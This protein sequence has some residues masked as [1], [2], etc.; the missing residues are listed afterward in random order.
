M[1]LFRR[2]ALLALLVLPSLPAAAALQAWLDR[3][4]VAP[5]E[6][7]ELTL[8]RDGRGDS[9]PDLAP[10]QR[11]FDILG[12]ASGTSV[13]IV[14]GHMTAQ[15]Q[16]RLTLSPKHDG[17]IALPPLN[18]GGERTPALVLSVAANAAGAADKA[19]PGA[20][21]SSHVFLTSSLEQKQPYVQA[22]TPLKLRLYTDQPLYQASLDL[23]ASNDVL[24]QQ[25]GKDR[26]GNETRG[27]HDYRVIERDYL[28]FPQRSGR[29]SLAGPLLQAQVAD[30]R[31]AG[32]FGN[33]FGGNPFAGM[34]N[35]TRPIHLRGDPIVLDARPRPAGVAGE[36]W[37]PAQRV[38]L[39]ESWRPDD[40]AVHAG[41]PITRHLRLSA[42]GLSAAQLPDLAARM[43]LP[44]GL[45]AYPDQ[46]RLATEVRDGNI[47]GSREQDIA[48]IASRPGR[49]TLP[50]MRLVWWDT[51]RNSPREVVLPARALEV[52]PG[53]GASAETAPP[54]PEAA[55]A[56]PAIAL[57]DSL[58]ALGSPAFPW[59]WLSLVLS[60]L[61][62]VTLL[63]WWRARRPRSATSPSVIPSTG[64][65]SIR[66]GEARKAFRRACRD[67]AAADARR[68][69]LAW[70]RATW[71]DDAPGGLNALARRLPDPKLPTLLRELDRACY[72]GDEW[73]GDALLEA[74]ATLPNAT[75]KAGKSASEL[76]G[77]YP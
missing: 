4:R 31:A 15:V 5:G 61:W 51:T 18:W 75:D 3:D 1:R 7:V 44:E 28:L 64:L 53:V 46:P 42:L 62:L 68:Q 13:Q 57:P 72:A 55:P 27:G 8:Q 70:A 34:M 30:A 41:E 16:L 22:A 50:A 11:D 37:L 2:L 25:I 29:I 38:D 23:P 24:V 32:P 66:A 63:A 26:Q 20:T 77:L 59:P 21:P 43:P 40:G 54:P 14:N 49:Y 35:A 76:A 19:S 12:K 48:L 10:L 45:K 69:L 67:N 17:R 39:E 52:L 60:L 74:L 56:A 9:Q 73:R 58:A 71:P 33:V 6:S 36:D 47:N 65:D